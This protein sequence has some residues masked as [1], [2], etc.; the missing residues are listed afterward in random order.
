MERGAGENTMTRAIVAM[1]ATLWRN[2][3]A[4]GR[5]DHYRCLRGIHCL[6]VAL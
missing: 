4:L 2:A 1:R 5:R 6:R 3:E